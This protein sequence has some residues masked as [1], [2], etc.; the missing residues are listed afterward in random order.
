MFPIE[1][2]FFKGPDEW[3]MQKHDPIVAHSLHLVQFALL[4]KK[5][6]SLSTDDNSNEHD[7]LNTTIATS[8]TKIETT[9]SFKSLSIENKKPDQTSMVHNVDT[10]ENNATTAQ[11]LKQQ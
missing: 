5:D 8:P 3:P 10:I 2:S 11:H 4:V 7:S 9:N 6:G 1:F